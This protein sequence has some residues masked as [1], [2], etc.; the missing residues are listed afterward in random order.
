MNAVPA[1]LL[2]WMDICS[3]AQSFWDAGDILSAQF[4]MEEKAV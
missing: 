2:D 1:G 3:I 4:W